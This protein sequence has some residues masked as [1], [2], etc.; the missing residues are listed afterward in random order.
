MLTVTTIN[1]LRRFSKVFR[2]ISV[3]QS[4]NVKAGKVERTLKGTIFVSYRNEKD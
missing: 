3:I 4:Q 2:N 1:P